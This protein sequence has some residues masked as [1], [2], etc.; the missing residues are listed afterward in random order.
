MNQPTTDLSNDEMSD[1]ILRR[2]IASM[3]EEA[4]PLGPSAE[5]IAVT[6][7]SLRES[8]QRRGR[9]LPYFPR[10]S[11]TRLAAAVA[12]LLLT[13]V[14]AVVLSV[15]VK[16]PSSAFGQVLKQIR[17]ASSMSYT[18]VMTVEGQPGEI[19]TKVFVS[20]DGRRRSEMPGAGTTTIFDTNGYIRITLLDITKTALVQQPRPDHGINAGRMFLA[21]L[22]DLKKLGDKPDKNLGQKEFDGK[23]A[24][25]FVAT[26]GKSSFTIWVDDGTGELARIEYDSL[27]NGAPAHIT[28]TDFRFDEKVDDAL[29]DFSVPAG[30]KIWKSPIATSDAVAPIGETNIVEALRGYTKR[31]GGKFPASLS[32]WGQWAVLFSKG[33]QEGSN[34]PETTRV[35]SHLGAILPFLISMPKDNYAYLGEGK[36]TDEKDAIVFWYRKPDGTYRAIYGDLSVKDITAADLTKK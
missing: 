13:V 35:M 12:G 3:Q 22:E 5:L 7:R 20:P 36:T 6:R 21:W 16:P 31:D 33:S 25:G 1:E 11:I 27:V 29:F 4:V 30:Y 9:A 10:T 8:D 26:L 14:T 19:V 17:D 34:D 18:Q 24:T 28:V 2:A 32:D 15:A 23:R